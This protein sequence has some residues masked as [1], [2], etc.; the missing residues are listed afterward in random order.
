MDVYQTGLELVS[1]PK[2]AP[3]IASS[4]PVGVVFLLTVNGR[5]LSQVILFYFFLYFVYCILS[6]MKKKTMK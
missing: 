4:A 3:V 6:Q 1:P 2:V 5:A